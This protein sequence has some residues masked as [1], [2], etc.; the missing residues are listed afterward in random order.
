MLTSATADADS[1]GITSSSGNNE[2]RNLP[3]STLSV[4]A[5]ADASLLDVSLQSGGLS[6]TMDVIWDSG[7]SA[8]A[9]AVGMQGAA[10]NDVLINEGV[11][12]VDAN[13]VARS[14]AV[15]GTHEGLAVSITSTESDAT[16]IGLK[17]GDGSDS[18]DV[19]QSSGTLS[20]TSSAWTGAGS[21]SGFTAKKEAKGVVKSFM[22]SRANAD[23]TGIEGGTGG[24]TIETS[25]ALTVSAEANAYGIEASWTPESVSNP[26]WV[27]WV[28][29]I[30]SPWLSA[31]LDFVFGMETGV[32]ATATALGVAGNDRDDT[33]VNQGTMEIDADSS[34]FQLSVEVDAGKLSENIWEDV[35]RSLASVLSETAAKFL[36]SSEAGDTPTT[37]ATAI[38]GGGGN[39][40]ITN[41]GNIR[42][43]SEATATSTEVKLSNEAIDLDFLLVAFGGGTESLSNAYGI[44][45]DTGN[46]IITNRSLIDIGADATSTATGLSATFKG[47]AQTT[48]SAVATATATA[49][50]GGDG[51]DTLANWHD[52]NALSN[53]TAVSV[54]LAATAEKG[55]AFALDSIFDGG[56]RATSTASGMSGGEGNDTI[57]HA[58]GTIDVDADSTAN[59]DQIAGAME[60][61]AGAIMTSTASSTAWGIN[62]GAGFDIISNDALIEVDAESDAVSVGV[63][64]SGKGAALA[65][66]AV[67]DGGTR[68]TSEAT[69]MAGDGDGD[70][71]TNAGV[72]KAGEGVDTDARARSIGVAGV[73]SIDATNVAGAV[74][75]STANAFFAGIDGGDGD[76]LL[77]NASSA[78]VLVDVTADASS[79]GVAITGT[80]LAIALDAV[81]DGGTRAYAIADGIKGGSGNDDIYNVGTV[82][83]RS[84]AFANSNGIAL[85]GI[86]VAGAVVTSTA[87]AESFA[88]RGEAGDDWLEN[89]GVIV[90][91]AQS[92]AVSVSVAV[93]GSGVAVAMDAVW[94]GG[95]TS[96]SVAKGMSGAGGAD[97][98]HNYGSITLGKYFDT[99]AKARSVGV[100]GTPNI[101][102]VNVAAAIV[103]STADVAF[104]AMDGGDGN[105]VLNSHAG[106]TIDVDA[107]AD[108]ASTS[109]SFTGTGVALALDA[110]WDGG[111][112][113]TANA[114]GLDA[115]LGN[116]LLINLG[117][118]N[119]GATAVTRSTGVAVSLVG[120]AGA[121]VSSTAD[122]NA[123]GLYGG[124]GNDTLFNGHQ[125]KTTAD[126][127]ARSTS[128]AMTLVGVSGGYAGTEAVADALGLDGGDGADTLTNDAAATIE[129]TSIADAKST[130]VSGSLGGLAG[131]FAGAVAHA[132]P[133]GMMG[134]DGAD[135]LRN[136]GSIVANSQSLVD[137]SALSFTLEGVSDSKVAESRAEVT[138][139]G[140][141][142]G[143]GNDTLLNTGS[144]SIGLSDTTQ[145]MAK[146]YARSASWNL[147]GAALSNALLSATS[148]ATGMD[149]GDGNDWLFNSGEITVGPDLTGPAMVDGDV[150]G[151][152]WTL[153]GYAQS[154]T[155]ADVTADAKG[156]AGG[157]GDDQLRNE[158]VITVIAFANM[159]S[160][161]GAE[162]KFGGSS[163]SAETSAVAKAVGLDGS[164]GNNTLINSGALDVT[165]YARNDAS[166]R[167]D[168][169]WLYG[170]A[171]TES[172]TN[173]TA[174]GYGLVT[175]DGVNTLSNTSAQPLR[176]TVMAY[177]KAYAYSDGG[178]IVNGD[179]AST[180]ESNVTADAAGLQAGDGADTIVNVSDIAV[181]I[182]KAENDEAMAYAFADADG[183]GVDG[184]GDG[185]ATAT[186]NATMAGIRAG[187]GEHMI[188][189]HGAVTVTAR[190]HAYARVQIDGDNTGNATGN[191]FSTATA[192]A[193]G[194]EVGTGGSTINNWGSLLIIAEPRADVS[195]SVDEGWLGDSYG[196]DTATANASATGIRTG[197]GD[198]IIT[199]SGTIDV[200]ASASSDY[201]GASKTQNAFGIFTGAG[202]DHID[203][204]G[205]IETRIDGAV[206]TGTAITSGAGDDV[207]RLFAN[208]HTGGAIDLGEGNDVLALLG[209][210]HISGPLDGGLGTDRVM[211]DGGG[212]TSLGF[213]GFEQLTKLGEGLFSLTSSIPSLDHID[214]VQGT[215]SMTQPYVYSGSGTH[216]TQIYGDGS[217]GRF[218]LESA[219]LDGGLTVVKGQGRYLDSTTFDVVEASNGLTGSFTTV[220]LPQATQLLSFSAQQTSHALQVQAHALSYAS[221]TFTPLA[222]AMGGYLDA[223]APSASGDLSLVMGELQTI[224]D[225]GRIDDA[226]VS[227]SPETYNG[228]SNVALADASARS[229]QLF[230][231]LST[232]RAGPGGQEPDTFSFTPQVLAYNGENTSLVSLLNAARKPSR[233]EGIWVEAFGKWGSQDENDG[234]TGYDYEMGGITLGYD[235]ALSE[236]WLAGAALSYTR[237]DVD[238]DHSRADGDIYSTSVSAYGSWHKEGA[239]VEGLLSYGRNNYDLKRMVQVGTITRRVSSDH[240][241]D[242]FAA[243]LSGGKMFG[244]GA[245]HAGP[246]VAI[247][248]TRISE[249][250]FRE[251]GA[252]SVNLQI[253]SR[254]TDALNGA[255]GARARH[256]APWHRG[257]LVTE[258]SAAWLHD[259]DIDDRN[260]RG[261]FQGA[262]GSAFVVPGADVE[263]NG[264]EYGIGVSYFD[265]KGASATLRYRGETRDGYQDHT[266]IGELR[267]RFH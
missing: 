99:D 126:A 93:S 150:S 237:S 107:T 2:F 28:N 203:N 193:V 208:S 133:T 218:E 42:L 89:Y 154:K 259:F 207:V 118:A 168:T 163:T 167:S 88:L 84:T 173:A 108:A 50:D 148:R 138:A 70:T 206:G 211:L 77:T 112:G 140:M 27:G 261:S 109:V 53:A 209:T 263:R 11:Q 189:N 25:G 12:S 124:V 26:G 51:T 23:A 184:D 132:R 169:G 151:A 120:V 196:S 73:A 221:A 64:L 265:N 6:L 160:N 15:T 204:R 170:G 121:I 122:A 86:G 36:L 92:D 139:R 13:A 21:L 149:G 111:T 9:N 60:G 59:S 129:V 198:Q 79:T 161:N 213:S 242:V 226:L 192:D 123:T 67:W 110:I 16:A 44:V 102:G 106:S 177:G 39:D 100:A 98:L 5:S 225:A 247:N 130:S 20:V 135:T 43:D 10:G 238:F 251:T 243:S 4:D 266:L 202:N 236:N 80:G 201:S 52:L 190:P 254:G 136:Y 241:G 117:L 183:D 125:V 38:R 157:E 147:I 158:G 65:M 47:V 248:Y 119:I 214:I 103:T 97:E 155:A 46:D 152:S 32:T 141:A 58:L 30:A 62:G 231:R 91:D 194:I 18:G 252:D 199:N 264:L 200:N 166:N 83:A 57:R 230:Q 267:Y 55:G 35:G 186:V 29:T 217:Y 116:D 128:V 22:G 258:F 96:S 34:A 223:I 72:I 85:A 159:V 227:L 245:W 127:S 74:V 172:S 253:D 220:E 144:I 232:L 212:T 1:K 94:D 246:Y 145:P 174:S 78:E 262:P 101:D 235:R 33:I 224:Q 115:G 7:T 45:G 164:T 181:L 156:M 234:S 239:Y 82:N 143:A 17:G 216:Q 76:D 137:A 197:D 61:I 105:D 250:S 131:A 19:I 228:V 14:L 178:D 222:R 182:G 87:T 219:Q 66:D 24:N 195:R 75:T 185:K 215:V 179:A 165:A 68:A 249:D 233:Q 104:S 31:G 54:G 95:T 114:F 113:A 63:A 41:L 90:A 48:V 69:G 3:G 146:A 142:G 240:E 257:E 71:I 40:T 188:D 175:G 244:E 8:T 171:T 49:I 255:L 191:T 134:G 37:Q 187:E 162:A 205:T 260:I 210:A 81:W 256:S 176:V 56:T 229:M 180:S 153:A